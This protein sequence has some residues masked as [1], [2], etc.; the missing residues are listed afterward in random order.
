MIH[1]DTTALLSINESAYEDQM[2]K[3]KETV[4]FLKSEQDCYFEAKIYRVPTVKY[5]V[6]HNFAESRINYTATKTF[7]LSKEKL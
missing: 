1:L 4:E 5:V 6:K 7:L 2:L 3:S